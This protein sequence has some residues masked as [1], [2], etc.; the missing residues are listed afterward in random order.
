MSKRLADGGFDDLRSART[1]QHVTQGDVSRPFPAAF[2]PAYLTVL[3]LHA[4]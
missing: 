2:A 3:R 1:I 4:A